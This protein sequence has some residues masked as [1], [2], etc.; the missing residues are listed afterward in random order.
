MSTRKRSF[1][2]QGGYNKASRMVGG[3][4]LTY[5]PTAPVAGSFRAR[6]T[7]GGSIAR[8]AMRTG[9]WASPSTGPE[10]KFVDTSQNAVGTLNDNFSAP[11]ATNLLNGI[12]TGSDASTRIG[13]KVILKSVYVRYTFQLGATSTGGAPHRILIVY[14]KQANATAPAVSDILVS[15]AFNQL[16]NLSNRDRFVTICDEMV[17]PISVQGNYMVSGTIYKTL[18]LET[19]F[20]AGSAGTIGDITSGSLY[21]IVAQGGQIGVTAPTFLARTRVRYT[22]N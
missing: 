19:M 10:L 13:R 21:M 11:G 2:T 14:D 9:G 22:D 4:Q 12:A 17:A 16:N 6:S 5:R 18:N 3:R 1:S 15:S 8:Q 20:N 7:L